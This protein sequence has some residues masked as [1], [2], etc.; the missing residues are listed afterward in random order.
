VEGQKHTGTSTA[1]GVNALE[2]FPS[3]LFS[4]ILWILNTL[5]IYIYVSTDII[6]LIST[7]VAKAR[8]ILDYGWEIGR[9]AAVDNSWG[10]ASRTQKSTCPCCWRRRPNCPLTSLTFVSARAVARLLWGS[11]AEEDLLPPWVPP[12]LHWG[13]VHITHMICFGLKVP[14]IERLLIYDWWADINVLFLAWL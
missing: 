9:L 7:S 5:R 3:I 11:H 13:R 12:G 1:G 14:K 8:L 2:T 6:F 4:P 10:R